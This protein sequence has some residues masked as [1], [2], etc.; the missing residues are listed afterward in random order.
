MSVGY[1]M[2]LYSLTGIQFKL[3]CLVPNIVQLSRKEKA[4]GVNPK[5]QVSRNTVKA[6]K[7]HAI[8]TEDFSSIPGLVW[9]E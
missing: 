1:T 2:V 5:L 7:D 9:P 8:H 4:A 6:W 3:N